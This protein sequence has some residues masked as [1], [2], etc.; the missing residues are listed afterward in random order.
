MEDNL[1][2]EFDTLISIGG[3]CFP[4]LYTQKYI[5]KHELSFFEHIGS[6]MWA[7]Q[8]IISN[9]WKDILDTSKYTL[10]KIFNLKINT[11]ETMSYNI[12]VTHNDYYLRFP[13]DARC[14]L[15]VNSIFISKLSRRIQR[16]EQAVRTA[17]NLLLIRIQE[18]TTNRINYHPDKLSDSEIIPSFIPLLKEKYGCNSVTIIFINTE[19]D[20]WN[21][22]RTI[23]YVKVESLDI[24]WKVAADFIHTLFQT[25]N[26][27]ATL[28]G[29][30]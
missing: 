8:A 13:H 28:S 30:V 11:P 24:D 1:F 3:N 18:N 14:L 16:F 26:V 19:Q 9:E 7:I 22:D 17:N 10:K 15:D 4:M 23:L 29:A 5:K 27:Y 25:K 12:K 21:D 2:P 20:G 6:S